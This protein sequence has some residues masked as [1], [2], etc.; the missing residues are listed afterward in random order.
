MKPILVYF[1]LAALA[2]FLL[3]GLVSTQ[4]SKPPEFNGSLI[5]PSIPGKDFS[6]HDQ[7]GQPFRLSD[8]RGKVVLL[9]FGYTFCPDVCPTTLIAFKQI[10]EGLGSRSDQVAFV[11]ITVDPDRDTPEQLKTH[12][13]LFSPALVGLT[14]DVAQLETVWKD[15]FINPQKQPG[16]GTAGYLVEHTGRVYVIDREGD[17]RLTFPFGLSSEAMLQDVQ[18]LLEE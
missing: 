11:F 10:S 13:T 6:L 8:Q 12:L 7:H 17:L 15:Y 9:F 2:G 14:D 4:T 3:I 5:E 16:A 1:G 18:H